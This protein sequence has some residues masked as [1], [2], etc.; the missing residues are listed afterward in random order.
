[1]PAVR[2]RPII[3]PESEQNRLSEL[4]VRL[5]QSRAGAWFLAD[6]NGAQLTLPPS[7]WQFL[8]QAVHALA[9]GQRIAL[10]PTERPLSTQ[11]AADILKVSRQHMVRLLERGE[12]PFSKTGS[13]RRVRWED[14]MEYQR[15]RDAQ[16][17]QARDRMVALTEELDL[18]ED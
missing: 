2:E 5:R 14:L 16:R 12:I 7:A 1:M 11:Q 3:A 6:R 8:R 13:H 15:M 17:R 18:Y 4:D 10:V 9:S